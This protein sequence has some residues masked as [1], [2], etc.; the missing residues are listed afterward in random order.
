[1]TRHL[2]KLIHVGC[3]ELGIDPETRHAMQYRLTE[4]ASMSEMT[5]GELKLVISELKERG[6]KPKVQGRRPKAKRAD[7]RFCHVMWRLLHEAGEVKVPGAEGL[8]AFI[9]SRFEGKWG[10]APMDIDVLQDW[11]AIND[12]VAALKDWCCRAGVELGQ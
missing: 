11:E 3:R 7:V 1:M 2:Q 6:F 4:K 5:E 12:V 10:H 8:N 9:R